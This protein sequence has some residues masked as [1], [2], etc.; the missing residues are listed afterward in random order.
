[1]EEKKEMTVKEILEAYE[2]DKI[3]NVSDGKIEEVE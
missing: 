1:M 3:F 2:G